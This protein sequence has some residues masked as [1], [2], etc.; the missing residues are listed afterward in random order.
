MSRLDLPERPQMTEDQRRVYDDIVQPPRARAPRP[1]TAWLHSPALAR[2]AFDFGEF[3]RFQTSLPPR[4][5]QLASLVVA[6]HWSASYLWHTRKQE[7]LKVG[8]D[9]V[10]IDAIGANHPPRFVQADEQAV[11]EFSVGLQQ[12]RHVSDGVYQAAVAVLGP[13]GVVELVAVLGY[14]TLVAMTL[15]SFEIGLPEGVPPE[16]AP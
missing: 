1:F 3:V 11:Y 16:L 4:L 2:R 7:A 5:A 14:Y 6:R 13:P 9:P 10:L 8:L 12:A 15:N